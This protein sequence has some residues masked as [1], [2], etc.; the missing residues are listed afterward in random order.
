M[1]CLF[2]IF[3]VFLSTR[4]IHAQ[5][6]NLNF[7]YF[8]DKGWNLLV[9]QGNRTDTILRG[10]IPNDGKVV[11][12]L[13]EKNKS[14]KGMARWMLNEGGGLD[15]IINGESFTVECRSNQPNESNIFYS[16]TTENTFLNAN[17]HEQERLLARLE[18][19]KQTLSLYPLNSTLHQPLSEE[20]AALQAAYSLFLGNLHQSSLYAARF[21][22]IVNFTRGIGETPNPDPNTRTK[23]ANDFVRH[24]LDFHALYT[25]NHWGGVIYSWMQLHAEMLNSDS[26]LLAST[27]DVLNRLE[28]PEQYT[29]FCEQLAKHLVKYGKDSLLT[30]LAPTVRKSGKLLH[31][32]GLLNQFNARTLGDE[33]PEIYL[34]ESHV[35]RFAKADKPSLVMFYQSTCGPCTDNLDALKSEWHFLK[36]KG[37][38]VI[39]LSAD[40]NKK[41]YLDHA[42]DFPWPDKACDL[43]GFEGINFKNFG[44]SGTPTIL[45][46]DTQGKIC[47]RYASYKEAKKII[48]QWFPDRP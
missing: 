8:A 10:T 44:V 48:A 36:K 39:T 16:G 1:R 25:S 24:T 40:K 3:L 31:Y 11:L 5:T 17:H 13:P 38:R 20:L 37:V 35:I 4:N 46:I 27:C 9:F 42:V 15:F 43:K 41:D 33:A 23:E 29:S 30:L 34:H 12:R 18:S 28:T 7:P 47:G 19:V 21:R 6:I 14:Y 26:L 45:A 32:Q 22:E 2:S